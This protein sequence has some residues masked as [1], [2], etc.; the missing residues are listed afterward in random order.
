MSEKPFWQ[1]IYPALRYICL[2]PVEIE[3]V[4]IQNETRGNII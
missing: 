3:G 2:Q 4:V 1:S